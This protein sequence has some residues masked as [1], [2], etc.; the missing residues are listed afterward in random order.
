MDVDIEPTED[1]ITIKEKPV[2]DFRLNERSISAK[3]VNSV[4]ILLC[5]YNGCEFKCKCKRA[6]HCHKIRVHT[7]HEWDNTEHGNAITTEPEYNFEP[8]ATPES[9][10]SDFSLK[11][12]SVPTVNI[13]HRTKRLRLSDNLSDYGAT[14][15]QHKLEQCLICYNHFANLKHHTRCK[16]FAIASCDDGGDVYRYSVEQRGV[17]AKQHLPTASKDTTNAHLNKLEQCQLCAKYFVNLRNHKKCNRIPGVFKDNSS[18]T[19]DTDNLISNSSG[20]HVSKE[21]TGTT[22]KSRLATDWKEELKDFNKKFRPTREIELI[23]SMR[24]SIRIITGCYPQSAMLVPR[25][26]QTKSYV[27]SRM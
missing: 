1:E 27:L 21:H 5:N 3:K 11:T 18:N 17:C 7:S 2:R 8:R 4:T 23:H 19:I 10:K 16:G 13:A 14:N 26:C 12:S 20:E 24:N 9:H 15:Q 22:R 25:S 6:L